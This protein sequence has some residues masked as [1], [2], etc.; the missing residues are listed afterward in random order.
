MGIWLNP[1]WLIGFNGS[2]TAILNQFIEWTL[3]YQDVWYVRARDVIAWMK[4]P[5]DI[6]AMQ[7]WLDVGCLSSPPVSGVEPPVSGVPPLVS[8]N[9]TIPTKPLAAN[10]NT[11]VSLPSKDIASHVETV[12]SLILSILC[13]LCIL[14]LM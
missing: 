7:S 6:Y 11:A 10:N 1:S 14:M 12:Y 4:N 8:N 5:Q 3:S 2:N 9:S 13:I